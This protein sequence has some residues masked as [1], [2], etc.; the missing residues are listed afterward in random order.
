[1]IGFLSGV[2]L[3]KNAHGILLE[4]ASG[5]GYEVI[6]TPQM[7]NMVLVGSTLRVYTYLK[8]S[9]SSQELFGFPTTAARDF[10][11]TLLTVSGIGPKSAMNVLTLGDDENIKAAITRGDVKY[12]TSVQ[13]MGKKTAERL[14]VE[15]KSKL[16]N[17]ST[18]NVE[19]IPGANESLGEIIEALVSMG[20]S[21]SEARDVVQNLDTQNKNSEG[22]LREA[23]KML[24]R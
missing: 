5:V 15:L 2:V 6:T 20:Y 1:M 13:G 14:V 18:N 9:D 24:A 10:F 8:V 3:E 4:T 21:Q 19:T 11:K 12:L 17:H 16:K 23:L 7:T 22:L